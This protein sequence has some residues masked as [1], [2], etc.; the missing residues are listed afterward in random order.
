MQEHGG[1]IYAEEGLF[2][3]SANIN[4]LGPG[5]NVQK[6]IEESLSCVRF[7][8]DPKCRKLKEAAAK[9]EHVETE[10]IVCGNGAADLIYAIVLAEKPKKALLCTPA[11]S[12]YEQAL[13]TVDCEIRYYE[14]KETD[15]FVLSGNY[16]EMLTEELD[17]AFLCIP[18]NPV[19]NCIEE[20]LLCD[21]IGQCEKK[22]IRLVLDEC[23]LDFTEDAPWV[24]HEWYVREK[25]M[26][27]ILRAFTKMYA[28]PGLR[29]GYGISKDEELIRKMEHVRQPWAVSVPAQAA[30]IAALSDSLLPQVTRQF[31]KEEREHL[32]TT[33]RRMGIRCYDSKANYILFYSEIDFYKEMKKKG[34][35]IRDCQNYRGLKKGFYR[36]AVKGREDNEALLRAFYEILIEQKGELGK[37]G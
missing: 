37:D 16:L 24:H 9:K 6:A 3:F 26:L 31:I 33:L 20:Q 30:G 10:N 21:I 12:E 27:F 28:V 29:I 11:F 5:E 17:I 18:D 4:P 8:P 23:F 13:H 1:D 25:K 34:F 7:Y 2:D 32:V 35:L 14:R 36:I 22:R 15:G 19:G